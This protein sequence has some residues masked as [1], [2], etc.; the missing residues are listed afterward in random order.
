[1]CGRICLTASIEQIKQHFP[2]VHGS[3]VLVPRYNIAPSDNVLIVKDNCLEFAQWGIKFAHFNQIVINARVETIIDKKA[4]SWAFKKQRCLVIANGFFEW[5]TIGKQ[6]VPFYI[7]SI[8]REILAFAGIFIKDN[9]LIITTSTQ[10]SKIMQQI[11]QRMPLIINQNSY[12]SWLNSRSSV[13][14]LL[15][16]ELYLEHSML[17]AYPVSAQVNNPKFDN[18]LCIKSLT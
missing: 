10:K 15:N 13:E 18:Q 17:E 5:K 9:C 6:K 16:P 1:M 4:F 11:H 2:I 14:V 12:Q 3:A 8:N 7:Q